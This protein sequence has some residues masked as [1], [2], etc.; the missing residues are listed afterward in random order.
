MILWRVSIELQESSL[1][2]VESLFQVLH[3]TWCALPSIMNDDE[4][5]VILTTHRE[6]VIG[7][8]LAPLWVLKVLIVLIF[9][10]FE[11]Y[12]HFVEFCEFVVCKTTR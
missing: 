4:A 8:V 10:V 12:W 5:R 2:I 7:L 9:G 11:Y 6:Q 3:C 1:H